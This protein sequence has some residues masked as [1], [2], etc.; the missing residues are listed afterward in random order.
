[1]EE[2]NNQINNE[3]SKENFE[4]FQESP[5]SFTD[6]S[7]GSNDF[8]SQTNNNQIN[9]LTGT[10][11][12]EFTEEEI[13][14][15]NLKNKEIKSDKIEIDES[16]PDEIVDEE[17]FI[18]FSTDQKVTP[19][20]EKKIK[21]L[22]LLMLV[23]KKEIAK[24]VVGQDDIVNFF[25]EALL[26]KGHVLVEGV[27][28]L[29]K[30][31]IVRTISI[32][33]GCQFS[34]IQFTP[35][36]L[37][38]DIVGLTM[39]EEGKGFYSIKGP[40]FANF[41][42]ADEINRA[43][44]KVQSALLEAMQERQVTIGKET[45]ALPEPFFVMAT[46]NPVENVGTYTLP[47]AQVDRFIFKILIGYPSMNDELQILHKNMTTHD[48]SEF[49]LKPILEEAKILEMQKVVKEVYLD[50]KVEKYIVTLID[51]TRNPKNYD[52]KLGKYMQFGGSPRSTIALFIA[53]KAHAALNGRSYVLPDDVKGIAHNVLRH[54]IMLNYE[55]QA[56]EIK[57]DEIIDELL[58]KVPII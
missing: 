39:Y 3:E 25:L 53:S 24:I 54:R 9:D 48:I 44:P 49:E 16:K 6:E 38:T 35:D 34:R 28:G 8:S 1:M 42:L 15:E 10:F 21:E 40:V 56:E 23:V 5:N 52:L 12:N 20:T 50:P 57:T 19:E 33:T 2:E 14:S 37:P 43:P 41:V 55:G 58:K 4:A 11:N 30:T 36:L 26:A 18:D 32:V 27:P 7:K 17:A 13:H 22:S 51:A 45:F 29:A 31:L 46:Q 47:E